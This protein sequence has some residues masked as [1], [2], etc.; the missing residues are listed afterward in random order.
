MQCPLIILA[1]L[2]LLSSVDPEFLACLVLVALVSEG[3]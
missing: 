3:M 2:V 1:G